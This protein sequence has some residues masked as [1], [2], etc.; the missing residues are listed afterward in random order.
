MNDLLPVLGPSVA[1]MI[2]IIAAAADAGAQNCG[3][4]SVAKKWKTVAKKFIHAVI[5]IP[6]GPAR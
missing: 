6:P 5:P 2:N 3:E 1:K 4:S